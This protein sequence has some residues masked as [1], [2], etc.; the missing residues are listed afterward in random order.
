METIELMGPAGSEV[1]RVKD[2]GNYKSRGYKNLDGTEIR[3]Q[4]ANAEK[5]SKPKKEEKKKLKSD[6]PKE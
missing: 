2:L 5:E 4:K 6:K 1:V 3:I